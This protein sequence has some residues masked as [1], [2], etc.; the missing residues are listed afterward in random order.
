MT[1]TPDTLRQTS[2]DWALLATDR[3]I[4]DSHYSAGEA[5]EIALLA[6]HRSENRWLVVE[7]KRNQTSDATVGQIL[8]YMTWVC[9]DLASDGGV[10]KGLIICHDIRMILIIASHLLSVTAILRD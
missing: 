6:K 10:V 9:L 5:E 2:R 1:R 3:E 7:L 8:L 4:V